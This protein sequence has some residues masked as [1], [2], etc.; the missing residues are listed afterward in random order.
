MSADYSPPAGL[1]SPGLQLPAPAKINRFVRVTG[2]RDDGYHQ[3]ETLFQFLEFADTMRFEV[4]QQPR[5]RRIDRHDFE[6]PE[7]DLSVRAARLL[8]AT[9]PEAATRGATITLLKK[10]PPGSGLGGGSSNAAT[11]LLALNHLWRLG[12]PRTRLAELGLQLGADVPVFVHGRAALATG[13]GEILEPFDPPEQWLCVC[14]PP[15]QVSTARVFSHLPL[16]SA[17]ESVAEPVAGNADKIDDTLGNDLEPVAAM[18]YPEVATA[19]AH[20]RRYADARLSGSGAA[21]YAAFDSREQAEHATAQLPDD[22]P[23]F[24]TRSRNRHP[25]G[26]EW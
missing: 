9:I 22:L 5:I 15:V 10:I 19:L 2:R 25:L 23:A 6:L 1:P 20:L 3:L 24:V 8:Q 4:S 13:I 26:Y 14:L 7:Q 11:T 18:L 16:K 17:A 21:V 12:V